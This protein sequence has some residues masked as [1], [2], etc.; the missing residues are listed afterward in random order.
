MAII[1]RSDLAAAVERARAMTAAG[2]S[3]PVTK[4]QRETTADREA[5]GPLL[6]SRVWFPAP[7]DDDVRQVICNAISALGVGDERYTIPVIEHV[8]AQWTGFRAGVPRSEPEPLIAEAQKYDCL[9]KEVS[10]PLTIL[11]AY[12]GAHLYVLLIY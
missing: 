5:K 2:M 8:Q 11:Y 9:M 4:R 1:S 7:S 6:V 10:S 3:G 12:G